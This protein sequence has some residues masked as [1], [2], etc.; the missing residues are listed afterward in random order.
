MYDEL[1]T[2]RQE[3]QNWQ[4]RKFTT[5]AA[6][7]SF[8]AGLNGFIVLSN[9]PL[10]GRIVSCVFYILFLPAMLL[11]WMLGRFNIKLGTYL[12]VIGN[13]RWERGQVYFLQKKGYKA[14]GLN[15]I[16]AILYASMAAISITIAFVTGGLQQQSQV[17]GAIVWIFF[18]LLT[19][20]FIAST[21]LLYR[22]S[23]PVNE[24]IQ[25]WKSV[26][27]EHPELKH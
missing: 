17:I 7:S 2:L 18:V 21:V 25:A 15:R 4:T 27:S 24:F 12:A 11:T 10:D 5:F 13:S 16:F 8:A 19:I 14:F 3:I 1:T 26:L 9:V 6:V 22:F 20:A 23:Y